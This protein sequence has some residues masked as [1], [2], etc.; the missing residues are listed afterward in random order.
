MQPMAQA[1]G[2]G[3]KPSPEGAKERLSHT[4]MPVQQLQP[5]L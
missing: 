5:V 2:R 1:V 3:R 4:G